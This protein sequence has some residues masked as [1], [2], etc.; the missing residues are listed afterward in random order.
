MICV[1]EPCPPRSCRASAQT[2]ERGRRLP[3]RYFSRSGRAIVPASGH[4]VAVRPVVRAVQHDRVVRDAQFIQQ[5]HESNSDVL[6]VV[7]HGIVILALQRRR[8]GRAL[9]R[10]RMRPEVHVGEIHPGEEG[11]AGSACCRLMKSLASILAISSS[12][13]SMRLRRQ[14]AR[15]LA[16]VC[17][18]TA[19]R[20]EGLPS[21]RPC[22]D[23]H[24]IQHAARTVLGS[25]T[26]GSF[27]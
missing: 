3:N 11:L 18:P 17:L 13:V 7:D 27:G 9:A 26:H 15:V 22:S 6:V 16:L 25:G 19:S 4:V 2:K 21:D 5:I 8:P 24:A 12:T 23:R 20:S 14:R 1:G 10:L